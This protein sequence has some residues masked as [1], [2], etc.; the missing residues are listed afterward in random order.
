[1]VKVMSG[2]AV[3]DTATNSDDFDIVVTMDCRCNE[4]TVNT[5]AP[6]ITFTM[7]FVNV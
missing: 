7:K 6:D 2:A 4:I 3:F 5:A 1:M